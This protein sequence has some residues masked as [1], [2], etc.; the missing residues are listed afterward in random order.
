MRGLA[1][2]VRLRHIRGNGGDGNQEL[3]EGFRKK[4]GGKGMGDKEQEGRQGGQGVGILPL[5]SC[6][7]YTFT[8]LMY[9]I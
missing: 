3:G 2:V 9:S 6:F 5:T 4:E 8:I 1:E 7:P